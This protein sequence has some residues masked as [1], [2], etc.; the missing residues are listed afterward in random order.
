[1]SFLLKVVEL[2]SA[3]ADAIF[4]LLCRI[5]KAL[6]GLDK[7]IGIGVNRASLMVGRHHS[8]ATLTEERCGIPSKLSKM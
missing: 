3:T 6:L 1:V 5:L 2:N 4:S 8:V 7:P